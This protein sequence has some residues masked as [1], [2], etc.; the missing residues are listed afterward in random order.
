MPL[1][2]IPARSILLRRHRP[3]PAPRLRIVPSPREHS[4]ATVPRAAAEPLPPPA[5][6]PRLRALQ[7]AKPFSSF[8][9]DRYSRRHNYLRISITERCNLRCLYCMPAEGVALSPASHLLSTAEILEL[10]RV[11]VAQGVTKIRLT[12]GEPTVRRDVVELV[13]AL[14]ALS[15]LGLREIAMTSNGIALPERKLQR[16]VDA[17]LTALNLSLDTLVPAKFEFMTRRKGLERVLAVVEQ[18]GRMGFGAVGGEGRR[19]LKIN[20]VVMRG[21]N[22]DEIVD[23]VEMTRS[24][25]LEVRFIE[26][27]PFDVRPSLRPIVPHGAWLTGRI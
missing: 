16:M 11:F 12:G 8:L 3:P 21:V 20:V 17:G 4:T 10:A 25:E 19:T 24:K 18:T 5:A 22:E 7:N 26:Y 14:G 1:R 2:A 9:T 15:P 27:M 23:F 13:E 6:T